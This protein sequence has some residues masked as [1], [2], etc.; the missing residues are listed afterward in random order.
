M[1]LTTVM[2]SEGT[3]AASNQAVTFPPVMDGAS[4]NSATTTSA[5]KSAA[6]ASA[7]LAEALTRATRQAVIRLG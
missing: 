5:A 7:P 4:I 3:A 2:T 1:R 6:L